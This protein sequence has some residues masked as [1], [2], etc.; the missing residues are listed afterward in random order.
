MNLGHDQKL[1]VVII[2][3]QRGPLTPADQDRA[4]GLARALCTYWQ[5]RGANAGHRRP[6]AG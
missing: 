4:V 5:R 1:P 3:G 6:L 2:S